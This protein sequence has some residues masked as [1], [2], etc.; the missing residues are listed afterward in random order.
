MAAYGSGYY[1]KGVYGIGN[2]VISGNA[3]TTAVGTL[4]DDRSIQEDGNIATGNVGTVGISLSFA[5]TGNDST[6][7]VNSVLVSPILT[8]SSSTGAVGTMSPETI[9]FVAITGVDGTGAVDSVTNGISIEII[10]VEASGSVGTM[11]GFGWG[12]IP[13]TAETWTAEA[14]TPETWSEISDNSETWTQV[15]A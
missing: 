14:D 13:D 3:S 1:G 2:V 8:G 4:L 12:A 11:I 9:S 10:G 6:L 15:P 5:I 7:S